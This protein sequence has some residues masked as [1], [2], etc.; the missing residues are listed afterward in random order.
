MTNRYFNPFT[1]HFDSN[2]DPLSGGKLYFY[3]TGSSTVPA[4]TYTEPTLTPGNENTNPVVL[5]S[6]GEAAT[7]I[8]LDPSVT[9]RVVLK[10]S[11]DVT[12]WTADNYRDP[13]ADTDAVVAVYPGNP[14]VNI[15]GTAGT[16]GGIGSSMVFDS[17]NQ[18]LYVCTTTGTASTAVWTASVA[19]SAGLGSANVFTAT[20][21]ISSTDAGATIGPTLILYRD[22]ASPAGTVGGGGGDIIGELRFDGEDSAGN[23]QTYAYDTVVITDPTSGSEDALRKFAVATAGTTALELVLSGAGLYPEANDGLSLGISGNAFADLFLA[24]GAVINFNAGNYTLTHSAGA[25]TASGFFEITDGL[26]TANRSGAGPL[27]VNR[28]TN[29]GTLV[30]LSQAT[31]VEGTISVSG[32]TVTYGTFCGSHWSQM[33]DSAREEILAGTVL[34]SINEKCV[35]PGEANDQLARC[36]ISDEEGSSAVYGVFMRWD[37]NDGPNPTNDMIVAALGAYLIRVSKGSVLKPGILLE[38]A[39]DGT[40]RVQSDD[41]I[42]ASTIAKVTAATPVQVYDD[43]SFTVPCTLHCG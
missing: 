19:G 22:S 34:E 28:N 43:G 26:L 23:Q 21:T 13:A 4:D 18:I 35:W 15:A 27:L 40:A 11:A 2:G 5:N 7:D 31:A 20:Q 32:T 9:Y 25:L 3:E 38:S 8:Y 14:N 29:D 33:K 41:I 16:F 42:R 6:R 39:G 10:T 1:Q 36:K 17:V 12:I 37:D 24:S 30:S